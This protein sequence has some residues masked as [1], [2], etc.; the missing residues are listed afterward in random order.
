[1]YAFIDE[2]PHPLI[3]LTHD[4]TAVFQKSNGEKLRRRKQTGIRAKIS[5]R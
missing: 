2:Q 4:D 5:E 1:M 3:A